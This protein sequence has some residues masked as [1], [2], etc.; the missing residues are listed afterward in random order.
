MGI[1][2]LALSKNVTCETAQ[3]VKLHQ[4]QIVWSGTDKL[5]PMVG[6]LRRELPYK[7]NT[8]TPTQALTVAVGRVVLA[9]VDAKGR[10]EGSLGLRFLWQE[11]FC[12]SLMG[13]S[14][15]RLTPLESQCAGRNASRV[16]N[17]EKKRQR[18]EGATMWSEPQKA[19]QSQ[20]QL[21]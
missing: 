5:E 3:P 20:S 10:R 12:P 4:S 2:A 15:E 18:A 7:A 9:P 11:Y 14:T 17:M 8:V 21:L 19:N 13:Y 1:L 6:H 16:L